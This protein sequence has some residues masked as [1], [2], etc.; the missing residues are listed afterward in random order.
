VEVAKEPD[1]GGAKVDD[2][3]K[4]KEWLESIKPGDFGKMEPGKDPARPDE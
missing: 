3:A 4:I 1:A 2:Q